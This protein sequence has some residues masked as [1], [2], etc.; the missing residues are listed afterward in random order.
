MD[1]RLRAGEEGLRRCPFFSSI[2]SFLDE[3]ECDTG[4][5]DGDNNN[6]SLQLNKRIQTMMIKGN[7]IQDDIPA[8]ADGEE[9]SF[10]QDDFTP[11]SMENLLN[12]ELLVPNGDNMIKAGVVK[13]AKGEDGNPIGIYHKNPLF[14]TREYTVE[15]GD[16]STAEYTANIIA[17]NLFHRLTQKVISACY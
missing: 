17:E 12:A 3:K 9:G 2:F 1:Q 13:R 7:K 16:G 14:D 4:L 10:E 15:F 8:D 6:N 5:S 11:N